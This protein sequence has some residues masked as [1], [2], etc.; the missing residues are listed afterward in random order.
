MSVRVLL[1]E[2]FDRPTSCNYRRLV[3]HLLA[4]WVNQ[5]MTRRCISTQAISFLVGVIPK[6]VPAGLSPA[7]PFPGM[8]KTNVL[9]PVLA[10]HTSYFMLQIHCWQQNPRE[11]Q[12]YLPQHSQVISR[13]THVNVRYMAISSKSVQVESAKTQSTIFKDI[14]YSRDS[15]VI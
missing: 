1:A 15:V 3:S 10:W 12:A 5:A 13:G 8:T 11:F 6:E 7:L 14:W 2:L 9:R 4:T